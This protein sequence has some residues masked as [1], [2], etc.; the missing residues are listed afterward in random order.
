[1]A[2]AAGVSHVRPVGPGR[3]LSTVADV[4]G[5][6]EIA[7]GGTMIAFG[8]IVAVPAALIWAAE[9]NS[10]GITTQERLLYG[11]LT[12]VGIGLGIGG[13]A[14]LN[15]GL[16]RANEAELE[17]VLGPSQVGVRGRF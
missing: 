7:I 12:C 11:G 9:E 4:P 1:M 3:A 16:R 14:L 10:F 6:T 8:A 13:A 2:A 17:V 15:R 5:G